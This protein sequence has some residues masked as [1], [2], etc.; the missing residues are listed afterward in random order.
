[1]QQFPGQERLSQMCSESDWKERFS[2]QMQNPDFIPCG[3]RAA[4]TR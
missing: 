2:G 1:M 4:L 3:S